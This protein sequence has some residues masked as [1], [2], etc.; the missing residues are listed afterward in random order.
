MASDTSWAKPDELIYTQS[1]G[2][3]TIDLTTY[4]PQDGGLSNTAQNMARQAGAS[5]TPSSYTPAMRARLQLGG[6]RAG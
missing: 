6:Q 3:I 4:I 1:A 5:Y 2:S